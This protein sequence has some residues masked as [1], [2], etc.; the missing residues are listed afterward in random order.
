MER[1]SRPQAP[2]RH[3]DVTC[4]GQMRALALTRRAAAW[5]GLDDVVVEPRGD[6]AGELALA[7]HHDAGT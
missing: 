2:E 7:L 1:T 6:L 5:Q 4:D 3:V